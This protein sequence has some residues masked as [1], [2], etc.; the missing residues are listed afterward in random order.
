M[1]EDW[2]EDVARLHDEVD[3]TAQRF[4]DAANHIGPVTGADSAGRITVTLDEE[5]VLQDVKVDS[6]WRKSL[7]PTMLG[8]SVQE[9]LQAAAAQR[10]EM[11]ATRYAEESAQLETPNRPMPASAQQV[12]T[13]LSEL[14]QGSSTGSDTAVLEELLRMLQAINDGIEQV[15]SELG[16]QRVSDFAGR[17]SSGHVRATVVGSGAVQDLTYDQRWI[18]KAHHFNIGRET[19]EALQD[20]YRKMAGRTVQDMIDASPLGEIQAL[21]RD[22]QALAERLRLL[23]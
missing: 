18:E 17:S 1:S 15:S 14:T 5:G 6:S 4:E 22:P 7:E 8:A 21:A 23:E 9:A 16:T 13:R 2:A 12:A 3:K 19:T 10:T 20:A 11:W